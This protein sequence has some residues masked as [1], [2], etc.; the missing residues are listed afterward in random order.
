MSTKGLRVIGNFDN[1]K[2]LGLADFVK[3][4]IQSLHC[5]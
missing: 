3:F 4:Q 5:F 1:A 2:C